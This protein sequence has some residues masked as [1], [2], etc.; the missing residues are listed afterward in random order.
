[1]LCRSRGTNAESG[2]D[3]KLVA[4][5]VYEVG[6]DWGDDHTIRFT[7]MADFASWVSGDSIRYHNGALRETGSCSG[8]VCWYAPDE[9]LALEDGFV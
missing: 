2:T 8:A 7:T 4:Y 3:E 5:H 1:M 6:R 9:R